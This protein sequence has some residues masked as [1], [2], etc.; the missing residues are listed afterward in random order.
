MGLSLAKG[1]VVAHGGGI[2]VDS[3]G[4]GEGATFTVSVPVA[5][6]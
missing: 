4:P 6:T 2:S 1:L 3:A 5:H